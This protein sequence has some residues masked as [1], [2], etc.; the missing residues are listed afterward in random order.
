M[1][2]KSL[3]KYEIIDWLGGGRFGDVF[4]AHDTILDKNFALKISRMRKD[5][6]TMLK[7]EAR[8]LAALDHPN[9]VRFYN[10]DFIDGKFVLVMEF[11]TGNTLRDIISDEGI[12]TD[13]TVMIIAQ[14]LDA[15]AYAHKKGVLHRDLKPENILLTEEHKK[16]HVKVTDFG[17]ARFIRSGSLSASTAGTPIYMAPEVWEGSYNEKS[18][19]WSIGVILYEMLTGTPPFLANNLD[20]LRKKIDKNNY[21]LPTMLRIHTPQY[22]EDAI[23]KC[24]S[25]IP[26]SRPNAQELI[27]MITRKATAIKVAHSISLPEREIN[28]IKLTPA[29]EEII[30]HVDSNILLLGQAGCGKTTTLTYAMARLIAK[31]I[32]LSKILACTFTNKAANDIKTRL[33][34]LTSLSLH[35]LWL[36]TFHKIGYRILKRDAERLDLSADFIIETPRKIFGKMKIKTGKHRVNAVIKFIESL[37]AKGISWNNFNA[38]NSWERFCQNIYKQY[39]TYLRDNNILDYDDLILYAIEL[40]EENT[41]IKEY[42]RTLFEHIFVDEL[43]DIN[44]AQ[45]RLVS[46]LYNGK[47]FF[48]GDE[49]QAIYGWRGADRKLI[50]RVSQDFHNTK[51]YNLTRSFRLPQSILELANNLMLRPSTAIPNTQTGEI[52]IYAAKSE[53]DEANYIIKEIKSLKKENFSFQDIAILYRMNSLSKV[54]EEMLTRARIPHSLISGTSL[55]ERSDIKP[56][57]EYLELLDLYAAGKN[58]DPAMT[59]EF[60]AKAQILFKLKKKNARRAEII[61]DRHLKGSQAL[62]PNR[63][64][65]E[66]ID[67]TGMVGRNVSELTALSQEYKDFELS[68]L[69]NEIK[70]IQELDLADWE[71]DTVKLLT[72]HSAKGL[73]FPVVFVVDLNEDIIPMTKKMA[74]PREIEEERRLCYVA[75][76]RAQRKLYLLYSKWRYGRNQEP[77]RFLVDMLKAK[78]AK[79]LA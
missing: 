57:I 38:E 56:I 52:M 41:D 12:R 31:G 11:V 8:L 73:E 4:L 35:D 21:L 27:K 42:Y 50:Y 75:L 3:G 9:I 24:L 59:T 25:Q 43:Q 47:I 53:K 71:K 13:R 68:R 66:L 17:L 44:Q 23:D 61:F 30:D 10:I 28:A 22:I 6:I 40:L 20:A 45:Y 67:A 16:S 15:I 32:P 48:T 64:I 76:T 2:L 58:F 77:S 65:M 29:Q 26:E 63:I 78:G 70:L 18:D 55:Y 34:H 62:T 51:T 7:D 36:G 46:L 19:I 54:Y 37:K 49:D 69:L 60:I 5:E 14:I 39:Q 1:L 72:V 33:G 79:T 74:S